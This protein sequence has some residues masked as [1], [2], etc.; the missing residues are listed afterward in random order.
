MGEFQAL[1]V[2]QCWNRLLVHL[3]VGNSAKLTVIMRS[4]PWHFPSP[5]WHVNSSLSRLLHNA[6]THLPHLEIGKVPDHSSGS[7]D[8]YSNSDFIPSSLL[9]S[10]S[11]S[12]SVEITML[13]TA[14]QLWDPAL[15]LESGLPLTTLLET[16]LAYL[17]SGPY[18]FYHIK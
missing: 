7:R 4:Q 3:A 15:L 8:A 6:P 11:P 17:R 13:L 9:E 18:Y 10:G 2:L 12:H 16:S 5:V 1:W 14:F